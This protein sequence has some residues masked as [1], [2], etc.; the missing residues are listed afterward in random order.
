MPGVM[1]VVG[2]PLSHPR[3]PS[4]PLTMTIL[5]QERR[6]KHKE[7]LFRIRGLIMVRDLEKRGE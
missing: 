3:T 4:S 2:S 5:K 7:R 1:T 6:A